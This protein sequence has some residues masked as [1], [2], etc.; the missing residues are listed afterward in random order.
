MDP[1]I[2]KAEVWNDQ[3]SYFALCRTGA[4]EKLQNSIFILP[5][6]MDLKIKQWDRDLEVP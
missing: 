5:F 2:I 1:S 4:K 3:G 6:P